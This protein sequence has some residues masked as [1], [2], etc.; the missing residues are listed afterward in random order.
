[1]ATQ[2]DC[3]AAVKA[4]L[5]AHA[6]TSALVST[7]VYGPGDTVPGS[8]TYPLL[9]LSAGTAH[10]RPDAAGPVLQQSDVRVEGRAADADALAPLPTA[11][12]A[13]LSG[14]VTSPVK[15]C[16]LSDTGAVTDGP[17]GPP[18]YVYRRD[19]FACFHS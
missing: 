8:P 16:L 15:Q 4:R 18:A 5:L 12:Q 3:I 13:A 19:T 10:G 2:A 6:A 7:R 1:M 9:V 11:V 14:F 17:G